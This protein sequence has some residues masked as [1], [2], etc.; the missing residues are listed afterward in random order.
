MI[1]SHL[2]RYLS[3]S[4]FFIRAIYRKGGHRVAVFDRGVRIRAAA[5]NLRRKGLNVGQIARRLGHHTAAVERVLA[6]PFRR[7]LDNWK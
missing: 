1:I 5:R 7:S 6:G 2:D 4:A 3:G